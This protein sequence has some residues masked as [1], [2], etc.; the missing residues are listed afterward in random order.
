MGVRA[1][2]SEEHSDITSVLSLAL[3]FEQRVLTVDQSGMPAPCLHLWAMAAPLLRFCAR[4]PVIAFVNV[5][6]D[7]FINLTSRRP[8]SERAAPKHFP[9]R[10]YVSN[11]GFRHAPR[12]LKYRL[13]RVSGDWVELVT[14][15]P[16]NT[17]GSTST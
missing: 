17:S 5:S 2:K 9:S 4:L 14:T 8:A 15:L 6:V 1:V 3:S 16:G 7:S 11:S 10:R 13:G 12:L